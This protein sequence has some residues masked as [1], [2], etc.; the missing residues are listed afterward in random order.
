MKFGSGVVLLCYQPDRK[1]PYIVTN[2]TARDS[3]PGVQEQT[4]TL[5]GKRV[6]MQYPNGLEI[7]NHYL[8]P[9]SLEWEIMSGPSKGEKGIETTHTVEIA[10]RIFFVSWLE[11]SG[12][13]VSHVIDFNKSQATV[14]VTIGVWKERKIIFGQG[15]FKELEQW[16]WFG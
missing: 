7:Q 9:D 12:T 13:T 1:E 4:M 11:R 16:S 5:S 2:I 8:S 14:F 3:S 10:P 6:L 15:A